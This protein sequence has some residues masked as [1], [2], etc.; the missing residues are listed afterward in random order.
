MNKVWSG[1]EIPGMIEPIEQDVLR[2]LAREIIF[3][4]GESAVEFGTFLAGVR[5]VSH[6][7]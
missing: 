6:Q 7:D 2:A 4:E 1:A 5:P 3:D